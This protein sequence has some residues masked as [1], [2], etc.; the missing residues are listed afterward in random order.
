MVEVF[1]KC[2]AEVEE[3]QKAWNGNDA[4]TPSGR[5]RRQTS[6]V[7]WVEGGAPREGMIPACPACPSNLS[8]SRDHRNDSRYL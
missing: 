2:F 8:L 6:E 7:H 5:G 1:V 3:L 4:E